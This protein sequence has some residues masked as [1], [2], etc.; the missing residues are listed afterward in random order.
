MIYHYV[1]NRLYITII[2]TYCIFPE[3]VGATAAP[4]PAEQLLNGRWSE[5]LV[6][7]GFAALAADQ[8]QLHVLVGW[9]IMSELYPLDP[10]RMH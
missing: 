9:L 2:Y 6:G 4:G 10:T 7:D 8:N 3:A 5:A 1:Y